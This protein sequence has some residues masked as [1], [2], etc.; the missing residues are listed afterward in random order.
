MV[1]V[2]CIDSLLEAWLLNLGLQAVDRSTLMQIN[3]QA[4]SDAKLSALRQF[5]VATQAFG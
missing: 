5:S 1:R 4:A 2:D 3:Q